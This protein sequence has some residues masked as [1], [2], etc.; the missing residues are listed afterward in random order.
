MVSREL[1]SG[2]AFQNFH[3][4]TAANV[5]SFVVAVPFQVTVD[6]DDDEGAARPMWVVLQL[7][8]TLKDAYFIVYDPKSASHPWAVAECT[9]DDRHIAV[10]WG[11]SLANALDSM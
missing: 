3:G 2:V 1:E 7:G 8:A 6:P 11:D 9:D 5:R 4:L 10:V